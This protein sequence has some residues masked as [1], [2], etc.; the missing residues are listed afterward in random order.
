M[1]TDTATKIITY[2]SEIV[3]KLKSAQQYEQ[4]LTMIIDRINRMY[5]CQT[6]AVVVIDP[7][8]EY[9]RIENSTGLSRTFCKSFRKRM[10]TGKIGKLLWTGDPILVRDGN[11]ETELVRELMLEKEFRSCVVLQIVV[12]HRAMG[13]LHVDS[14]EP[15]RFS[16]EDLT[17]LQIFADLA[18]L[19]IDKYR[20]AEKMKRLIRIDRLT[21][22]DSYGTFLQKVSE[23]Y[24]RA[25]TFNEEF[26]LIL[27]DI[28][29][30][31]YVVNT[32]GS[33]AGDD[34]LR[35]IGKIVQDHL[36]TV[37]AGC[38]Y[39]VDDF[40][41]LRPNSN[42]TEV[43][44]FAEKLRKNVED[45]LFTSHQIDSTVSVGVSVYPV[46]GSTLEDMLLT[47]KHAVFEAQRAGRNKVIYYPAQWYVGEPLVFQ[48]PERPD[49]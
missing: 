28:D 8:T 13:Y 14:E 30:F 26:G 29:N 32:Y 23:A 17:I 6:C 40:I 39:G 20:Q 37:D 45:S 31:K 25:K 47:G 34:L 36:R 1:L 12:N 27:F 18:G 48:G 41:I 21:G 35:Q 44:E 3:Q 10:A 33:D 7:K 42:L 19:A 2:I 9:L 16:D 49:E 43:C 4:V 24:E 46:N 38:R 15:L 11:E 5:R 22:L